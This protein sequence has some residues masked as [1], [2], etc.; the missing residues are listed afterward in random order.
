MRNRFYLFV[1]LGP[2]AK[3]GVFLPTDRAAVPNACAVLVDDGV[4]DLRACSVNVHIGAEDF[5]AQ[6]AV[7]E[8]TNPSAMLA[9]S[10]AKGGRGWVEVLPY[11]ERFHHH[12]V[13]SL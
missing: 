2:I 10:H 7:A 11:R 9:N 6:R 3:R 5:D 12:F 13:K 1:D 4:A 8:H